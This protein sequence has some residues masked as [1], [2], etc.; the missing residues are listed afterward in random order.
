MLAS[1]ERQLLGVNMFPLRLSPLFIAVLAT[2]AQAVSLP[3]MNPV[4]TSSVWA[5]S[6]KNYTVNLYAENDSFNGYKYLDSASFSTNQKGAWVNLGGADFGRDFLQHDNSTVFMGATAMSNFR[7]NK[8]GVQMTG[9]APMPTHTEYGN[10]AA[11]QAY[12]NNYIGNTYWGWNGAGINYTSVYDSNY[13][14]GAGRNIYVPENTGYEYD[15]NNGDLR[16]GSYDPNTGNWVADSRVVAS[17]DGTSDP[18]SNYLVPATMPE[19]GIDSTASRYVQAS[20]QWENIF[21][22]G[23]NGQTG[24]ATFHVKL[25]GDI[26]SVADYAGSFHYAASDWEHKGWW[27]GNLKDINIDTQ[28]NMTISHYNG[29]N[30]VTDYQGI[31][32]PVTG[33]EFDVAIGFTYGTPQYIRSQA[34]ASLSGEGVL[35]FSHSVEILGV[36]V[37]EG[38]AVY[39]YASYLTG[40]GLG[41]GVSGGGV[42][43]NTLPGGSGAYF[44]GGGG[45]PP[46]V[47]EPETYALMLAGLA[48]V[49]WAARRRRAV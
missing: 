42:D 31:Y 34:Y 33:V 14:G 10:V 32:D 39:S 22:F 15:P 36:E 35:D 40:E 24:T 12:W 17:Y 23:G 30:W 44:G 25:T 46:P 11:N 18:W 6:Q 20:S 21:Y 5:N 47:P 38:T 2:S 16:F 8:V 27:N 26:T 49:G 37:P 4:V 48:L 7:V 19:I 3:P 9:A 1:Y 43:G 28:G 41:F 29:T 45:N 13:N